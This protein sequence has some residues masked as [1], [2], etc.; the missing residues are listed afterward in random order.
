MCASKHSLSAMWILIYE[1]R[2]RWRL[3]HS[4]IFETDTARIGCNSSAYVG[5]RLKLQGHVS[6]GGQIRAR[7]TFFA[8]IGVDHLHLDNDSYVK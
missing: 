1:K 3:I 8:H 6:K 2:W 7:F 5:R 4:T